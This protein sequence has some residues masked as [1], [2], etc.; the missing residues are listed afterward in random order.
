MKYSHKIVY[1][2]AEQFSKKL[3]TDPSLI[4]KR[5]KSEPAL[6]ECLKQYANIIGADFE[7]KEVKSAIMSSLVYGFMFREEVSKSSKSANNSISEV[8]SEG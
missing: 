7:S 4:R 2:A 5:M 1:D 6:A 3:N 8:N